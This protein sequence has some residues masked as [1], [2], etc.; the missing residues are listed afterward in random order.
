LHTPLGNQFATL[1]GSFVEENERI[2]VLCEPS[3]VDEAVRCLVRIGL[4]NVASFFTPTMF[5]AAVAKGLKTAQIR[6][7][8]AT[9]FMREM[10]DPNALV[11]DVRR[12]SEYDA[13]HVP[14]SLNFAHTRLLAHIG[15]VPGAQPLL[16]HCQ[17]G[18][19]SAFA[20]ALLERHGFKPTNIAGGFGAYEKAGGEVVRETIHA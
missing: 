1:A 14:G 20:S 5:D 16:V 3:Q 12:G 11:L 17:G 10:K 15:E 13:G 4:D 2:I 19:R 7:I 18:T 9:A 8:D 6:E